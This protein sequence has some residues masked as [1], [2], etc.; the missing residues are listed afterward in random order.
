MENKE[1]KPQENTTLEV[2][3]K[4]SD[5]ITVNIPLIK[6]KAS[7]AIALGKSIIV[8]DTEEDD[9]K[10]NN[11]MVKCG[12]TLKSME[13]LRKEF[14][15]PIK[16][17]CDSQA[18]H[19]KELKAEIDRIKVLRN[20][21]ANQIAAEN[22]KK[23]IEIEMERA[24][25][26][27]EIQV[28][29]AIKSNIE[30]GV[31]KKLSDL[32]D[33]IAG[34]FNKMTITNRA[35]IEKQMSFTPKLREDYFS[36][37]FDV[38]YDQSIMNDTQYGD[39]IVRARGYYTYE[40][41]NGGYVDL[42][43]KVLSKWKDQIPARIKELESIASGNTLVEKQANERLRSEE[44]KRK[45]ESAAKIEQIK[46]E[47]I[48]EAQEATLKVEF[49]A[50]VKTQSI[51]DLSGVRN[52]FTLRLDPAIE[53]NMVK[54]SAIVAKL[55]IHALSDPK[56]KGIF[57]RDAQGFPKHDKKGL[58]M[59]VDGIQYWLDQIEKIGYASMIE[60]IVKT[61]EVSTIAKSK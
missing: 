9:I 18:I 39:L 29:Q 27:H 60:G 61:D 15:G 1:T 11:A 16:D 24:F 30:V 34:M 10:A 31:A 58:P 13:D 41:I 25:K 55:V 5:K 8:C 46:T 43:N 54:I 19:E 33:A 49:D 45:N 35:A 17:W 59:Y 7:K 51:E 48:E 26:A 38:K 44:E 40:Q 28:K 4:L 3:K 22:A 32:E 56:T 50:Q 36:G 47:A 53:K 2:F 57:L 42:A 14:T 23:A 12:A 37:L 6:D 52:T 20:A 21:R